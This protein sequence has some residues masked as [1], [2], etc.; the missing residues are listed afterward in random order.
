MIQKIWDITEIQTR[1]SLLGFTTVV[2]VVNYSLAI[3]VDDRTATVYGSVQLGEPIAPFIVAA[4]LT[5]DVII[6]WVKSTLGSTY[7]NSLV[8]TTTN[9][10]INLSSPQMEILPLPWNS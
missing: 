10:A 4:E 6:E 8:I 7:V 5:K 1:P 2:S 3:T 9:Q